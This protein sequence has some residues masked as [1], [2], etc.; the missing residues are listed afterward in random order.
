MASMIKNKVITYDHSVDKTK[1]KYSGKQKLTKVSD[2]VLPEY[3]NINK[4]KYKEWLD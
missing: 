4:D 2:E 1:D 3:V